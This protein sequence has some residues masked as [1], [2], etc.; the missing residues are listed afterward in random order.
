MAGLEKSGLS[1]ASKLD[2]G[3]ASDGERL[4]KTT[5]S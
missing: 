4:S 2:L 5:T 1:I 3:A